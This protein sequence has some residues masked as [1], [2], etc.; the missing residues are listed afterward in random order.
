M[1]YCRGMT[2]RQRQKDRIPS[3]PGA[4]PDSSGTCPG[5]YE[6]DARKKRHHTARAGG[7][8]ARP[9][10][11]V[12][13]ARESHVLAGPPPSPRYSGGARVGGLCFV[14]LCMYVDV[15]NVKEIYMNTRRVGSRP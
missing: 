14:T 13:P 10:L 12:R 15:F 6:F 7:G 8:G 11:G 1:H 2:R 3:E 4:R 9:R 5:H